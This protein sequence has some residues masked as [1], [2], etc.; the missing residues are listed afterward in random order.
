MKKIKEELLKIN[1]D[2]VFP[3]IL[4]DCEENTL[5]EYNKK[6]QIFNR[7]FQFKPTAIV[8]CTHEKH[9]QEVIKLSHLLDFEIRVRSGGHDHEGECTATDVVLIDFSKMNEVVVDQKKG[10]VY[11][12]PGA[13]FEKIIPILNEYKLGIPHGT[14]STV[15]IA[16]Y[17]FGGGW[18]PWTRL[19]GMGCESL[20]G[21]T[22]ILGNGE[23]KQLSENGDQ[24]QQE[25][26]WALRGGGGFSYGVVTELVYKTFV[27]PPKTI[28]FH[29][30][31]SNSP[32]LKV[33]ET[34]EELIAPKATIQLIGTNLKI[35]AKPLDNQPVEK[36]IHECV[37][38]GY[39]AGTLK[40]LNQDIAEWFSNFNP[41]EYTV[42]IDSKDA[43]DEQSDMSSFSAWDRISKVDTIQKLRRLDT[44]EKLNNL[45]K[46]KL[47]SLHTHYGKNLQLIPPD[48]D[49]PAPHKITSR[50]VVK[51][52]L[53]DEGR[54]N[55]IKSLESNLLHIEGELAL[56]HCYVTLGAISGTYYDNYK[57]EEFPKGSAFPYKDR[58]YFIQYQAWWNETSEAIEQGKTNHEY[59]YTNEAQD[60]IEVSR[61]NNFPQTKGAF[62]SFKDSAVPTRDYFLENF[63]KLRA[64]KIKYSNDPQNKFRSRKTII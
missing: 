47:K 43:A 61:Q 16:G 13:R 26:L 62:I 29:I 48:L 56:I 20:V 23:R 46:R 4:F 44:L 38:Y 14:C 24:E 53:G 1:S 18:G 59:C 60:W 58:P 51:E 17:T 63:D 35:M 5:E 9:V 45:Q 19:H 7:K 11:I 34:W 50:V 2:G 40:A 41:S 6:R 8:F 55:L 15:G 10:L 64:I 12:Q 27:Q 28:K 22:I 21:A 3:E 25:M 32:A 31:W 37:F 36:S 52:G 57:T 30:T 42:E 54:K 49:L 39:Y 33:L